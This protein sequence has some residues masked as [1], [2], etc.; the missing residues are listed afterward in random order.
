MSSEDVDEYV[1]SKLPPQHE[2]TLRRL[3]EL[4]A[5]V[6][7]DAEEVVTY[8]SPA[9]KGNKM[10]AIVSPTKTHITLAFDHGVDF[11]DPHGLLEGVGKRSRHVKLKSV[12]DIDEA[13]LRDYFT[14]AV[15][16]DGA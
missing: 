6:A 10:L 15:A 1:K 12:D 7:P 5:E 9:W 13:A 3:R 11:E 4:V 14:Q 16:I 8:G 2:A